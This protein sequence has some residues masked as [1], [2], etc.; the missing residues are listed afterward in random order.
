MIEQ[1]MWFDPQDRPG[2]VCKKCLRE[3]FNE[4]D[5]CQRCLDRQELDL[6]VYYAE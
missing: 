3:H 1:M 6:E 2:K 5:L 4:G